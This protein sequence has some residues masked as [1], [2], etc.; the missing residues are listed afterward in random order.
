MKDS[1]SSEKHIVM[2]KHMLNIAAEGDRA[3]IPGVARAAWSSVVVV[4]RVVP[5]S[6]GLPASGRAKAAE[7]GR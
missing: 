5:S 6:G 2:C 7:Q 1:L 3:L 4:Q